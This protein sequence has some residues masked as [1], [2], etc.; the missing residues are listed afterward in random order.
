MADLKNLVAIADELGLEGSD[1]AAFF[2]EERAF[3]R[4]ERKLELEAAA[5]QEQEKRERAIFE[6]RKEEAERQREHEEKQEA[7][8]AEEAYKL[9]QLELQHERELAEMRVQ[10]AKGE[11]H[12][13]KKAEG[14]TSPK[15]PP[16]RRKEG[17]P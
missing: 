2:R 9:R 10:S 6:Q 16:L 13:G 7:R 8:K 1:R 15:L 5:I 17:R 3:A 12:Q 14:S 11:E 4:E